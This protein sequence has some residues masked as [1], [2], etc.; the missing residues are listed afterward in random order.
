MKIFVFLINT[1]IVG[2]KRRKASKVWCTGNSGR[3]KKARGWFRLFA[4]F[5]QH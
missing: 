2:L 4:L 1:S 5:T 3:W